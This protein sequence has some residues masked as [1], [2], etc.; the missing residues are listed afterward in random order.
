[1]DDELFPPSE[2]PRPYRVQMPYVATPLDHYKVRWFLL[3]TGWTEFE[4]WMIVPYSFTTGNYEVWFK[5]IGKA[6]LFKLTF[7]L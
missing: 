5:D 3:D 2:N 7:V 4:E 6:T 1:M